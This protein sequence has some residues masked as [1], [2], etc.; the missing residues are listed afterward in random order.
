MHSL[1]SQRPLH[2]IAL[3]TKILEVDKIP[4]CETYFI[5]G[6]ANA[7]LGDH[8]DAIADLSI[9]CKYE[10]PLLSF[11]CQKS[12]A[13]SAFELGRY[14]VALESFQASISLLLGEPKSEFDHVVTESAKELKTLKTWVRKCNA[15]IEELQDEEEKLKSTSTTTTTTKPPTP[16]PTTGTTK[17]N[18]PQ[19]L[20][21]T[22]LMP[23]Y[24]YYQSDTVV[25][26]SLLEPNVS[27]SDLSVEFALDTLKVTLTKQGHELVPINGKLFDGVVVDKC[28]V[29]YKGEKVNIKLR[30]RAPHNWHDLFG[31]GAQD[32]KKEGDEEGD[33]NLTEEGR[34]AKEAAKKKAL[35]DNNFMGDKIELDKSKAGAKKSAYSS[36]RDWD[37]IDR[38]LKKKEEEDKG[39]GEEALN[40]LFKQIYGNANEDTRRAMIKS[41]QTSGGTSLSTNWNEVEKKD[42]EAERQAPNG[43]EWKNWEGKKL[44]Q[45]EDD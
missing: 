27:P 32:V 44:P 43:M 36:S 25:T 26:I 3:T 9:A 19:K 11:A 31:A 12:H 4:S 42:Y 5:R 24:Q 34:K 38:D 35:E 20:H 30:K 15:E 1:L 28:K 22:A 45:K 40:G 6:M 2:A 14:D 37:A 16:I 8:V 33:D 29:L 23:K 17:S 39:E 41:F 21:P 13:L 18:P 7:K 10:H